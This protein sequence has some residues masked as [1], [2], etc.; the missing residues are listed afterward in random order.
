V[1]SEMAD[2]AAILVV[3]DEAVMQEVLATL[4][5]KEGYK[6]YVAATGEAGIDLVNA[7]SIDA[8]VLDVMMPGQGGMVTLTKLQKLDNELPVVMLTAY[9]SVESAKEAIRTGAFDYITK[10]FKHDEVLKVLRNAVERRRLVVE[11]R[12]LRQNLQASTHKFSD[13]VGR[14]SRIREVFDLIMQA[15]PSRTTILIEGQSGTGKELIARALHTNSTRAS[16]PF[17]TVSSGNLPHD[18]FE[19]NLF[20]HVKGAFTGALQAKKGLFEL[21]DTG[22][23]FFDEISNMSLE[24]QAKLL[25]VMQEREFMR[26]GGVETVK[27]DVR[28]IAA[29]NV[30]LKHMVDQGRFREDLYYRLHV[31]AVQLPSLRERREDI[32]LLVQHF[33][34]KYGDEN[35]KPDL[36]VSRDALDLMTEYAW[37]GN[38][39]ELENV[40]ERAVVLTSGSQ[41]HLD[42]IPDYVRET[43]KFQIPSIAVPPE[44]LSFKDVIAKSEKQLLE[45]ALNEA[46]GVQIRAAKLLRLK[47]S[48]LNLMLKRY[49]IKANRRSGP[50]KKDLSSDALLPFNAGNESPISSPR[51]AKANQDE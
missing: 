2:E 33:L 16:C 8:V 39:R 48:T 46:G 50:V 9:G 40:I 35:E 37:P 31:I 21:A 4:L 10:P 45:S 3:D 28:V 18:L 42:L 23:I 36:E 25:G 5:A 41:I 32:P 51:V 15:A 22:T 43:Q 27:V 47:P 6:V 34:N 24:T 29:T 30:E 38:V 20:G 19:S 49:N 14:S 13:I 11:N 26:L 7:E 1:V 17:I 44:G 12:T